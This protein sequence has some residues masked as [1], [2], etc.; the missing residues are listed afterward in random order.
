MRVKDLLVIVL[1]AGVPLVELQAQGAAPGIIRSVVYRNA[2]FVIQEI[3]GGRPPRYIDH[4]LPLDF[5]GDAL[6][7]NNSSNALQFEPV[8]GAP[9]LYYSAVETGYASDRG[10]YLV[11]YYFYHVMD[12][13]VSPS[14]VNAGGHEHDLEGVWLVIKKSPYL[15]Y[16]LPVAALSEA[17]G[18][19]IP[20]PK[21][22]P[23]LMPTP[24]PTAGYT[25]YLESWLDTRYSSERVVFGVRSKTHGTYAAQDC[26][27]ATQP[28]VSYGIGMWKYS[29]Q[30]YG[31]FKACIHG[32][33]DAVVYRPMLEEAIGGTG[34]SVPVT[35]PFGQR[36]GLWLYSLEELTES[37]AWQQ[38]NNPGMLFSG[39]LRGLVGG[40]TGYDFMQSS[41]GGL[42]A[43]PPWS[44]LGGSGSNVMNMYWYD[45]STDNTTLNYFSRIAWPEARQGAL[46][47]GARQ[48]MIRRFPSLPELNE[49]ERWNPYR[50]DPP[51]YHVYVPY[52]EVSM[53]GPSNVSAGAAHTWT[54]DVSSGSPP[55]TYAW[56]G[57]Q[58]GSASSISFQPYAS[59]ELYLDVWDAAGKHFSTAMYVTVNSASNCPGYDICPEGSSTQASTLSDMSS[60]PV[61]VTRRSANGRAGRIAPRR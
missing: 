48:E 28:D 24:T 29:V 9:K 51:D 14:G 45:W 59:G 61:G 47:G 10:Y 57:L 34:A 55:F 35:L 1:A 44:W 25:G 18:A 13:G 16:G 36:D 15:P 58:H 38:R 17:H 7:S 30:N 27:G 31:E 22:S 32:G 6:G 41:Y 60:Q 43:N 19:L 2:P 33:T 50:A 54:A 49:P 52:L 5:D 40:L 23:G 11:G 26:S 3:E 56:S 42:A 53:M 8:N 21:N 39:T 12:D 46:L 20:W 4:I 37:I